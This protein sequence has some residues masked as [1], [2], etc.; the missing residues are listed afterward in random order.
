[1]KKRNFKS[2]AG[3]TL[4]ELMVVVAI[5]G[6]LASIAVPQYSKFQSKAR[7]TEAKVALGAIATAEKSYY[8]ESSSFTSCANAI[9]YAP[10]P[11]RFYG[12]GFTAGLWT[13][14]GANCG[15]AAAVNITYYLPTTSRAG[16]LPA[17]GNFPA[18]TTSS[19][20]AFIA[21]AVGNITTTASVF[22]QWTIDQNNVLRNVFAGL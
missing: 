20:T 8:I 5:I 7:Q 18:G 16:T 1:M 12:A 2:L 10:E 6:I 19:A 3:F 21:G 13:Y 11:T 14:G 15:A 22:D 4:I 9:G 17:V